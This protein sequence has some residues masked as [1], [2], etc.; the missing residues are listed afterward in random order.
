MPIGNRSP[1]AVSTARRRRR[2]TSL[3]SMTAAV[4][5]TA[6]ATYR[7]VHWA[8]NSGK[9]ENEDDLLT[10]EVKCCE[11]NNSG[12]NSASKRRSDTGTKGILNSPSSAA[13]EEELISALKAC[14]PLLTKAV[15]SSTDYSSEVKSLQQNRTKKQP[16][17]SAF[18][19]QQES[20]LWETIKRKS[21]TR[22]LLTVYAQILIILIMYIQILVMRRRGITQE[23]SNTRKEVF[24]ETLNYF[25]SKS[26]PELSSALETA[27]QSRLCFWNV[28]TIMSMSQSEFE[29]GLDAVRWNVD[30]ETKD[31][32]ASFVVKQQ[33]DALD[34]DARDVLEE[35][36]D[37]L[38]SPL[39]GNA[40]KEIISNT[41]AFGVALKFTLDTAFVPKKG[42]DAVQTT[43]MPLAKIITGL[44]KSSNFLYYLDYKEEEEWERRKSI[45]QFLLLPSVTALANSCLTI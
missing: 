3:I 44:K 26:L 33:T 10:E 11:S 20:L 13:I 39:F 43:T 6:Y 19:K 9:T 27:V 35:T 34:A 4:A 21:I 24:T 30:A 28:T 29:A 18:D 1:V 8:W 17:T 16:E 37:I 41:T 42:E 15:N 25:F 7:L 22:L 40:W 2:P 45:S 32:I 14:A 36:W 31:I 12:L 38:E 5:V 23:S